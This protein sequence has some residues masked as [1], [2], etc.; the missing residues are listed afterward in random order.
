MRA[1]TRKS[2][3]RSAGAAAPKPRAPRRKSSSSAPGLLNLTLKLQ[4]DEIRDLRQRV[5]PLETQLRASEKQIRLALDEHPVAYIEL[6]ANGIISQ[7]NAAAAQLLGPEKIASRPLRSFIPSA[8]IE[9]LY[10]HV[11]QSLTAGRERGDIETEIRIR[12]G[13]GWRPVRLISKPVSQRHPGGRRVIPTALV[14]LTEA[15]A[16]RQWT[17]NKDQ[18][19]QR[20][21]ESIDG[22]VWEADYPFRL[23][24]VSRQIERVLGYAPEDWLRNPSFW[25]EHI[26]VDDRERFIAERAAAIST[27]RQHTIDYRMHSAADGILWLRDSVLIAHDA[28]GHTSLLGLVVN[29]SPLKEAEAELRRAN[30]ELT[31]QAEENRRHLE[32]TVQSMETFCYGIAHELR[33][34][35]RAARGFG[36]LL[37]KE[38]QTCQEKLAHDYAQRIAHAAAYMDKLIEDLLAYGRLHHTEM[39]LVPVSVSTTLERVLRN[40]SDRITRQKAKLLVKPTAERVKAHPTLLMQALQ[41]LVSNALKFVAPG[42]SPRVTVDTHRVADRVR[43]TVRDNGIGIDPPWQE[44]IFGVFQRGHS[45]SEYPGTGI[46]LAMVK[47][48]VELMEGEVG[49]VSSSGEGSTFWIE[50]PPASKD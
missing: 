1:Q 38:T 3:S 20:L 5:A 7:G 24:F 12:S 39:L 34:P 23:R 36:D 45:Q 35:V 4:R 37:L 31:S 18:S 50:L 2:R 9:T 41:N 6:F 14:D 43:I 42:T 47:R 44:R 13:D 40:L 30:E 19:F 16:A 46:G 21:L 33:A 15:R 10:R 11:H 27:R 25:E 22:I 28:Q 32:Q 17:V 49:V 29:I 48:I 26:H 8:D